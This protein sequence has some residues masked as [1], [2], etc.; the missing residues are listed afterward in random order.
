MKTILDLLREFVTL[1]DS[2]ILQGGR[3]PAESEQRWAELKRFYDL[4]M[5]PNG[6]SGGSVTRRFAVAEIREGVPSR[7]H[8]RVPFVMDL[9][10]EHGG[11]YHTGKVLNLS[12]GG[13]FLIA[14]TVLEIGS[15]LTVYLSNIGRGKDAVMTMDGE[16]AWS[17]SASEVRLPPGM[18]IRFVNVPDNFQEKLDSFVLEVLEKHFCGLSRDLLDPD[19]LRNEGIEL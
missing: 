8:L 13:L 10:F 16:V 7:K 17:S 19:F 12:G 6:V 18:G 1:N 5:G 3:L 2:K 14:E 9:L 15:R 4:L 11:Q